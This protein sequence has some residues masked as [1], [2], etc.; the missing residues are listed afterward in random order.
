MQEAFKDRFSNHASEYRLYRPRY[1]EALFSYL[2][3]LAPEREA[4]WDCATGNGQ[5]AACLAGHFKQVYATDASA[6]QIT[7]AIQKN[8]IRYAVSPAH[9]TSLPDRSIDLVTI[10]QAVH[11]FD[12]EP[13]Y[14]EVCRVM[15]KDGVIAAWAYHLPVIDPETDRIIRHL[16]T[17]ILDQ[18]WEE[19]ITHIQ[20]GYSK[21]HLPFPE[22]PSPAFTM[23]ADWTLHQLNGYLETWSAL[24]I[25][26]QTNGNN[27]LETTFTELLEAWG[28]PVSVKR[29]TWPVMLKTA[30]VADS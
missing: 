15:K 26:R 24:D 7:H 9:K 10:A 8:N 13:F 30:I 21:I 2:A 28:N 16:Y 3:S 14:R 17:V 20:S 12:T 4:A 22:I 11:W 1:P 5:A 23:T 27:P 6:G 29:V 19:E 25:Y 18:F